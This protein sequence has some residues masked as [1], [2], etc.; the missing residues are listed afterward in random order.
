QAGRPV[1]VRGN[2]Q[3]LFGGMTRLGENAVL[4]IKNKSYAVT[5]SVEVPEAGAEGVIIAQG[6]NFG[7]WALYAKDGCLKYCYNFL[8]LQ[9]FFVEAASPLPAGARQVRLEFAYDGGGPGKG[10]TVSLYV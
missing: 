1:L 4:N 8:G 10:G 3:I 5:A 2:A 6:G 7:G 9:T